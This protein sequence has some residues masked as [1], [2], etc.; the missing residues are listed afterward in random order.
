MEYVIPRSGH[1]WESRDLAFFFFF[2]FFFLNLLIY[3]QQVNYLLRRTGGDAP[4]DI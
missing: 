4:P 3:V 2:F 1:P